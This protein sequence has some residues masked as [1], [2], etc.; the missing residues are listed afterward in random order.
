MFIGGYSIQ[1]LLAWS[2]HLIHSTSVRAR[3]LGDFGLQWM[4]VCYNNIIQFPATARPIKT[5]VEVVNRCTRHQRQLTRCAAQWSERS[6]DEQHG[7]FQVAMC[8]FMTGSNL[9]DSFCHGSLR[10]G[11]FCGTSWHKKCDRRNGT[12]EPVSLGKQLF[13]KQWTSTNWPS[14]II[15]KHTRT[16][17]KELVGCFYYCNYNIFLFIFILIVIYIYI[18]V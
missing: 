17:K 7:F 12:V 5:T 15:Q 10:P 6:K 16:N 3:P 13:H 11:C 1:S 2:P 8:H 18:H 4:P 9:T 14:D